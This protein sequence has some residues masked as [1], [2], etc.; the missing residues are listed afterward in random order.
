MAAANQA[1]TT[2]QTE[3]SGQA[4]ETAI[5]QAYA[6]DGITID[7]SVVETATAE[8][9]TVNGVAPSTKDD[10]D[11]FDVEFGASFPFAFIIFMFVLYLVY[12]PWMKSGHVDVQSNVFFWK[13][14]T[15]KEI[16]IK[17]GILY[18]FDG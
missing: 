4:L 9:V 3:A 5:V 11:N 12:S 6:N 14:T 8:I 17:R 2:V 15:R 16:E 13:S 1:V 10:E 7:M 18:A